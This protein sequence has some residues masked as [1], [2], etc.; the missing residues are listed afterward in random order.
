M[1]KLREVP[2][3]RPL[4]TACLE[5][6]ETKGIRHSKETNISRCVPRLVLYAFML[7]ISFNFKANSVSL[8][9][10]V[11]KPR[12]LKVSIWLNHIGLLLL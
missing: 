8:T 11:R 7:I 10:R 2:G 6:G 1:Q 3:I 12:G 9:F 4:W 5:D